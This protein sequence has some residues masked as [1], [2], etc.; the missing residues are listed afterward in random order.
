MCSHS[1]VRCVSCP[2]VI[3]LQS[4]RQVTM[5]SSFTHDICVLPWGQTG[6]TVQVIAS[7][8]WMLHV[9]CVQEENSLMPTCH[10][11]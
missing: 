3:H 11:N 9:Q 5:F 6:P 7:G 4:G 2:G 8:D 1:D 10:Q